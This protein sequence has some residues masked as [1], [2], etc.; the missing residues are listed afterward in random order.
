MTLST[1]PAPVCNPQP[2]GPKSSTGASRRSLT[3]SFA[4]ASANVANEDC[5]KKQEKTGFPS[6]LIGVEPSA[7]RPPDL[8]ARALLQYEVRPAR[9]GSHSPHHGNEITT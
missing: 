2:S 6:R 3:T 5:W 1:A 8:R 4:G 9:Q 7:R